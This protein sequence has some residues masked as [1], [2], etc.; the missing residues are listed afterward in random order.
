MNFLCGG[1]KIDTTLEFG[2]NNITTNNIV[3]KP[4]IYLYS[5]NE[6]KLDFKL[7]LDYAGKIISQYPTMQENS[8]SGSI[9]SGSML[10]IK[11][12]EY[13]YLFWEGSSVP[14]MNWDISKGFC[15]AKENYENFLEEALDK[16]A[17][18][19]REKTDFI[20]YWLPDL[21]QNEY[22]LISFPIEQYSEIA[23][24]DIAPKPK[25]VI[26]LF[27]V[28][29]KLLKPITIEAPTIKEIKRKTNEFHVVEWGGLN[30]G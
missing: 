22:S 28:F 3:R 2:N 12:K 1:G 9:V 29:K 4:V 11:E 27:M 16:F 19:S 23:K 6:D 25:Q 26:R 18:S 10:S 20:T 7:K 21:Q 5:P 14:G 13:S 15:V 24:M 17:F 30:L 8:W